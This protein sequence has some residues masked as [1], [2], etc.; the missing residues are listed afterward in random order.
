MQ[1]LEDECRFVGH[2]VTSGP[3]TASRPEDTADALRGFDVDLTHFAGSGDRP[4]R[5]RFFIDRELPRFKNTNVP[6]IRQAAFT[7][8]TLQEINH[9]R[10]HMNV[11]DLAYAFRGGGSTGFGN[12]PPG[13]PDPP[14]RPGRRGFTWGKG[15][16]VD[17]KQDRVSDEQTTDGQLDSMTASSSG[18]SSVGD[19]KRKAPDSSR[20]PSPDP[21]RFHSE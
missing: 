3:V 4:L 17:K 21:Q 12:N 8:A 7:T 11:S 9:N 16:S 15:K 5:T 2:F 13:G 10:L 1:Q 14:S 6:S 18:S 19:G 20:S